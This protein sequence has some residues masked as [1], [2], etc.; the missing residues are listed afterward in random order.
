MALIRGQRGKR[1]CPICLV[2][3]T[4]LSNLRVK[5]PER[6][7]HTTKIKVESVLYLPK[8][9]REETLKPLGLRPVK[10]SIVHY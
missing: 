4:E 6:T 10:A 9:V 8:T 3:D 5:H 2:P 7:M 1:P